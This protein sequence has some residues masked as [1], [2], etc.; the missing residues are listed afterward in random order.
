MLNRISAMIRVAVIITLLTAFALIPGRAAAHA[1]LAESEPAA[2]SVLDSPPERVVI[3]FTEPLEAA[4][5]EIRVLDSRGE[6]VDLG[7]SALD[8]ADPTIMSVSLGTLGNGAYTVAWRN[9]STVDGHSVRG[10]FLFSVGEP[11]SASVSAASQVEDQPL[12]QSPIEPFVRWLALVGGLALVGVLAFRLLVSTP[13]LAGMKSEGTDGLRSALSRN[14]MILAWAAL[15]LFLSM[16]A[17]RLVIQASVVYDT[18]PLDALA[19]PVWSLVSETEWGRLWLMRM[20]FAVAA[21]IVLFI[22]RGR[23]ENIALSA[24][25]IAL[26]AG[27]L[28]TISRS[29]HAAALLEIGGVS[30]LNDFIH[31]IAVAVWVGGL[32]SLALDIPATMRL[33]DERERR[34]TLSAFIPRF[35]AVAGLSVAVLALTGIYSAWTQVT[36]PEALDTPYGRT[37]LVKIGLVGALLLAAAVNLVWVRPRLA[38]DGRAARWL[39]RLVAVEVVVAIAILLSVG[40]LTSLEPARQTAERLGIGVE[41]GLTFSD[42]A[43]GANMT[44]E[45]TPGQV[46][47]NTIRITLRDGFGEPITN[48][49]DVRV[50]LSYLDADLGE[51]AVSAVQTGEGEFTLDD[52]VIGIAGAWEVALVAQRPD[53]FDART[54]FRFETTDGGKAS[55]IALS[56]ETAYILLGG[57]FGALGLAFLVSALLFGGFQTRAGAAAMSLGVLGVIG[58]GA[59]MAG[60]LGSEEGVPERNPIPATSESVTAGLALYD[61]YCQTCHGSG[62]LGD[63]PASAGLNPPVANL[64]VHVPLHPDRALFGFI[65]DGIPEAAMPAMGET[66]SDEEIWHIVNYIRTLE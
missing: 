48:A 65:H 44:L 54:A 59:L 15:A 33:L 14:T 31:M 5:S 3:R 18:S 9:V 7:D 35:S 20:G 23:V 43:E 4:L 8:P 19:G 21:G 22:M 61:A 42:T 39:R 16:S 45:I 66:L 56:R 40:F 64:V 25:A 17:L 2:N 29:S 26:G 38:G 24:L 49:T 53:A 6:R 57:I 1:N 30:M 13:A 10:A 60:V 36:I 28:L 63:G 58:A 46:G 11:L 27:A 51:T 12:L 41:D 55:T 62:G 50:R 37:L 32:F 52:Q 47:P 34:E